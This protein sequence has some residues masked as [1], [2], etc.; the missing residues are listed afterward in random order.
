MY[1]F[2]NMRAVI[3]ASA[4]TF[5]DNNAFIVKTG[6]SEYD[7]ITY[8]RLNHE[9]RSLGKY[10]V[11]QNLHQKRI[12]VI[13]KN[14]YEWMLV[15]LSVLAAGGVIV[16]LDKGL[17][18]DEINEQLMRA[19]AEVIFYGDQFVGQLAER[20]NLTQICM[21]SEEFQNLLKA[22]ESL[23]ND[24]DYDAIK[25]DRDKMS[26]LLFTSGTTSK[27]KAVMLCQRNILANVYGMTCWE[28]FDDKDVNL[29]ILPFHHAFGMTQIVLFLSLGMCNVFCEG[30]RIAKALSEYKVTVL[31]AVPRIIESIYSIVMGKLES[32]G[33]VGKMQTGL[34]ITKALKK[35]GI[36]VR[37]KI[38]AEIIEGLGGGLRMVIVGAAPA[39]PDVLKWFNAIGVLT[40]QG[41]GL[42]ETAPTLAAEND[43]HLRRATVG[44]AL[45][46]VTLQIDAPDKDGIG[47]IIAK[48]DNVMLGYYKDTESTGKVL[49]N[50]WFHTGD[51]GKLDKDGYLYITGRK[52]NVIVL[53]NGKN[54]FPEELEL[55]LNAC[56]MIKECIVFNKNKDG[57]DTLWAKVV[58]D[59]KEDM[60]SVRAAV[61]AHIQKMNTHLVNYKQ[62]KGFDLTD[63]EMEKTTTLKIKR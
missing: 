56:P 7:Y 14:S 12:A 9:V 50:G 54:V 5:P 24:D 63:Q 41:Y 61:D 3:E 45:P 29:A 39:N 60:E 51:M 13:G 35:I 43:K 19:E 47:E 22:G 36:D 28:K 49:K 42:T 27:S 8:K 17:F 32:R 1:E 20:D 52:K 21:D 2:E 62:I 15:Y 37:R 4:K 25:I 44:L 26:L 10:L 53:A 6:K 16:P 46:N 48:G 34:K 57:R 58:Y 55:L 31:V 18:A 40:V 38:F 23:E 59:E 11:A 33:A 30:L